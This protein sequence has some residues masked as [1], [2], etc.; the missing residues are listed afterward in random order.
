MCRW[1]KSFKRKVVAWSLRSS[2]SFATAGST[3]TYFELLHS[4]IKAALVRVGA[5]VQESDRCF[6]SSGKGL[7]RAEN[8]ISEAIKVKVKCDK[9]GVSAVR[10]YAADA[11][12]DAKTGLSWE[13]HLHFF[14]KVGHKE[15]EQFTFHW[16]DHVFNKASS[17]LQVESDQVGHSFVLFFR[18]CS[19]LF[20]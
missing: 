16:W 18:F 15:G 12:V 8:G 13:C 5:Q 1:L 7:G 19:Y 14:C 11:C 2:S 3:V 20:I 4:D 10:L 9:G 6:L 17:S